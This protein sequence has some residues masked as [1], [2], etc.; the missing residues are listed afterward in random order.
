[1]QTDCRLQNAVCFKSRRKN[2]VEVVCGHSLGDDC[3]VLQLLVDNGANV[4]AVSLFGVTVADSASHSAAK[5]RWLWLHAVKP[6]Q[7]VLTLNSLKKWSMLV[8]RSML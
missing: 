3:S 1:M 2:N 5:L 6:L 4:N 8:S 7:K